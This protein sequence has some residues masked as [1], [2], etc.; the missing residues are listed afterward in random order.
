MRMAHHTPQDRLPIGLGPLDRSAQAVLMVNLGREPKHIACF[1]DVGEALAGAVPVAG[2]GSRD[3]RLVAGYVIDARSELPDGDL[4]PGA[5]IV[6][7]AWDA[8]QGTGH[9]PPHHVLYKN[10][11]AACNPILYGQRLTMQC[12]PDKG[13][14]DVA[15]DGM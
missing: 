2:R 11:V 10:K 14:R 15:P 8:F 9:Q 7:F 12:L 3:R 4:G 13:G 5:E 6:D 1:G